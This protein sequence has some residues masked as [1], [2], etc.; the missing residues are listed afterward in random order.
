MT[1]DSGDVRPQAGITVMT[2]KP[3]ATAEATSPAVQPADRELQEAEKHS[4]WTAWMYMFDWYVYVVTEYYPK[5]QVG[6]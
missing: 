1:S 5:S 2:D 6:V 4:V 3:Q